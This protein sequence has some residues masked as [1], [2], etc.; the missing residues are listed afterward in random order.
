[1]QLLHKNKVLFD[2]FFPGVLP[3]SPV[4]VP[5]YVMQN[6][7]TVFKPAIINA[8][9]S[10]PHAT[11]QLLVTARAPFDPSDPYTAGEAVLGI[12]WYNVFATNDGKA[13]LGG[14][15]FDN[16]H[17]R[18]FGSDDDVKLNQEVQRFSA[19][20]VARDEINAH[21]Q[22]SGKL[23]IPL[24]TLHTVGDPLVPY[25]HEP[26]YRVKVIVNH[27]FLMYN[28]IHAVRYGHCQFTKTEELFSFGL[29]VLKVTGLH[30]VGGGVQPP[31]LSVQGAGDA[32]FLPLVR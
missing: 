26:I 11:E 32:L 19:D 17:T 7:E 31:S 12:L 22:T 21:F 14:Q 25:W 15:P 30:L 13:T 9:Q 28:G 20:Q 24:V 27:S 29:L 8:I 18:Y 3:G 2:Y 1:L 6:W 5:D 23:S 16:S 10:N 4:D